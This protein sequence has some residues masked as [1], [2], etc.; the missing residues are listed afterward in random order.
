MLK[1]KH[2]YG[3]IA[4]N[5]LRWKNN[6]R[7][8]S[9]VGQDIDDEKFR[10]NLMEYNI[11]RQ[12]GYD[13][14]VCHVPM[15]SLYF[16]FGGIVTACC[17]NRHYE[18][19]R[20]PENTIEEIINGEK[21][22]LLQQHLD[23]TDFSLGCKFCKDMIYSGDYM[24]VGARF[25]DIFP[26]QGAMPSEMVFELDNTCNLRCKMC[27]AKFSSAHDEGRRTVAPYD[28]E[29]FINQLKPFVPHLV[30]TKF[31][32]GEPFLS[33]IYPKIWELIIE[34]NPKCKIRV[35]S[36]GT[37]LNDKL[38]DILK[39]GNFQIGLSIDTLNP[40]RY[41][42]IRNGA[43]IE[44]TL[45]NLE[46][47]NQISRK[48]GE[49]MS[50]SV[51]PMKGNRFDIPELVKFCNGNDIFIYFNDVSTEGYTLGELS[52]QELDEL[53]TFYKGSASKANNSISRY[54]GKVFS[55][56]IRKVEYLKECAV[57]KR[58]KDEKIPYTRIELERKIAEIMSE[59]P[60]FRY[61]NAIFL[62]IP[63]KFNVKR[64]IIN[65]MNIQQLTSFFEMSAEEQSKF[66][67]DNFSNK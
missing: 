22:K 52:E 34:L 4:R 14:T 43:E 53:A 38:K 17:F 62:R 67:N 5:L 24:S 55:N 54:N 59:N 27:N 49:N 33:D 39:R 40:E 42:T 3:T 2:T 21:R 31:L 19:G 30:E 51:C 61:D 10:N 35:Q 46:F 65:G 63:E 15:R 18:L 60:N 36:N 8:K 26:P 56:L 25:A 11:Q 23:K 37:I 13:P 6:L 1:Q 9:L 32:G 57:R 28:N 12:L 47:F 29:D 41:A 50:I 58:Y 48:N 45:V 64:R 20:F 16:G 44:K 7:N 66:I